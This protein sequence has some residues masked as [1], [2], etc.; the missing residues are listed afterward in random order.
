MVRWKEA[1]GECA[2]LTPVGSGLSS[3]AACREEAAGIGFAGGG[4][5]GRQDG[6]SGQAHK[7]VAGS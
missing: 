2:F 4:R 1:G 6:R 3:T 5:R 7:E